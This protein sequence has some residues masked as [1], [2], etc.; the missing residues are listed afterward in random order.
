ML[1][2]NKPDRSALTTIAGGQC[3]CCRPPWP[4]GDSTILTSAARRDADAALGRWQAA[5]VGRTV[6]VLG[7][8][9]KAPSTL[10]TFLRSFR[11]G[12]VR[13]L[14]RVSRQ[15]L[16]RAWAAGAGPGD[17]PL[18]IDLDST[19]CE[20]YG[21]AKEGARHHGYT[22]ARG[23]HPLLAIAAGT[24]EVLM[25][26]LREGRANTARGAA[27]F[28][29]ETVGRVRYGGARGQLTVRADSG[30][31]AH[32][33]V[34]AC[35]AMDVRFSITIRQRA[36]LR[37]LIEVIP[38]EDWTPIPYWMDGAADVA[39]TT[40]IPFQTKPDAAPVRLIVRRVKPAPGSQLALFATYSYHGF[41]TDRDGETL[42]LEAD[43]RRHA[44][45][46]NAIRD[47]KYGVGLNHLPS[48]RFAANGAWLAVQ[49]MAHNLA[50]WTARIGLGQQIVTTKTLRRRVFALAGRITRSARR[51]TLHLPRRWP[52][53]EQFSRALARLRAIPL[54]A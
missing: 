35:R 15:L 42:E 29:R 2:Q 23:Y 49:V 32:T 45:I 1:P 28:L 20:T 48:G 38:E 11:W 10:G 8:V 5:T 47:L 14:D 50:R 37:D 53:E 52:W 51:L 27:H 34:A 26:R 39:E 31:Y 18:T 54:P 30:F 46:E 21:L 44:E 36:S 17:S 19:I 7:C 25:S 40:Y 12:H 9:V 4:G 43:H 24:G 22:G 16:A 33:V 3:R 41:I 6:G 13:Q